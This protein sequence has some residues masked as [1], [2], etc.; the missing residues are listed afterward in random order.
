MLARN[1]PEALRYFLLGVHYRGPL[2]FDTEKLDGRPRRV[3]R[4][5]RGRAP[6]R[7]PLRDASSAL[8]SS[9]RG[10]AT[11]GEAAEGAR[12]LRAKSARGA[13]RGVRR[14]LDDDLNTPVA[15][16]ALGEIAK[17]ANELC[18]LAPE[19]KEGRQARRRRR[20]LARLAQE[21]SMK[22]SLDVLGLLH[23]PVT[24]LP[25]PE[26]APAASPPR[27]LR[28]RHRAKARR[29]RRSPRQQ[30]S[31]AAINPRRASRPGVDVADSPTGT[32]LEHAHLRYRELNRRSPPK[33]RPQ[34]LCALESRGLGSPRSG[35]PP[36]HEAVPTDARRSTSVEPSALRRA[37]RR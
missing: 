29:T 27:P 21:A 8:A 23:A 16:A 15:L 24:R 9:R 22:S 6:R 11:P 37:K 30:S 33:P 4:R 13:R 3:P 26:R 10:A 25:R 5:R 18:D 34:K 7:L 28:N 2:A 31:P 36:N 12:A 35:E 17:A 14:A 1:D 19:A 20:Q 32:T